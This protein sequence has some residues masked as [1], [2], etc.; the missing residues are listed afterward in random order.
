MGL[1]DYFPWHDTLRFSMRLMEDGLTYVDATLQQVQSVVDQLAGQDPTGRA[2]Q[3]PF[4][5]PVDVEA[6]TSDLANRLLRLSCS[7]NR[8]TQE[9]W[10]NALTATS[11]S[12]PRY[13]WND[14][15]RLLTLPLELPLAVSSLVV[16]EARRTLVTLYTVRPELWR[17]FIDFLVEIFNDLPIYFSLQY[18]EE[19]QRYHEHLKQYPDDTRTRLELARTYMKC[20]LFQEAVEELAVVAQDPQMASRAAYERLIAYYRLGDYPQ[21]IRQGIVCVEQDANHDRA[22][23]WLWLAAQKAGGYPD[24]VPA[25]ARMQVVAGYHPTALQLDEVAAEIGLDKTCGGRGT[26]VFDATGDG[27][28]DVVIAGAHAGCSL[29]LNNGDGTFCDGSVGS[30]LDKCVYGFG[31]AVGDYTNNGLSDLFVSGLGFFDGQG[32]LM[33]NNGDGTFTDVTEAAGLDLWGPAFIGTWVDTNNNGYLDLFV[34]NNLGGLFDRKTPNRLFRNNGDGTFTDVTQASGLHTVW[35]SLGAAWGDFNNNGLPDLFI[36]NMGRA[37]LYRNNGDGTFTDVSRAAGID[38]PTIGSVCLCCDIDNDGW[39]DIVQFTYSYAQDAIY[40]LRH[41]HG[42][43]G[44]SPLRVFRNNRDGTFTNIAAELGLHGCWGTMSGTV[45]DVTNNGYVDLLLGNGDPSIDRTEASI[46]L[47]NDGS[48]FHNVT[49]AAGM[50][51]TGKGHGVNMADLAGD[52]RLHLIVGAGG[53][54]PGDLLT[55][56]VY[57]P[58]RRLGNYLNVRLVGTRSNRSAIGARLRLQA[59][60]RDQHRLVS[61][62]SGF[63]CLP[64]EQHFGLGATGHIDGLEIRWPSGHQQWVDQLPV[65]D[66]VRIVEGQHG[67]QPVYRR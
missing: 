58:R 51:F 9:R 65:N 15:W 17:D 63:G 66:T 19:L 16:Q 12:F 31:L 8:T 36:S 10:Q 5:G 52:G 46:L 55:T 67:W 47:A 45:G 57:R 21:A 30:G 59:S 53:L 14:P 23:Y 7:Y 11:Q 4:S 33:R 64:F 49:F 37:Q 1:T 25:H 13:N 34:V 48:R 50:P 24:T 41:G 18:G 26:A 60:G 28:L 61:G 56:T 38:T 22:R 29:F 6:A 20:G 27:T 35:P 2:R 44:G 32:L 43:P 3:A 40:T 39:L 42:P 54:Y 62:G